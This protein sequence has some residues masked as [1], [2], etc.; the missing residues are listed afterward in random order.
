[1][2]VTK[3]ALDMDVVIHR[4]MGRE[5]APRSGIPG[6]GSTKLALGGV[7]FL[8]LTLGVLWWQVSQ[9]PPGGA[10]LT[11]VELRWGYL[12]LILLCLPV[13]TTASALRTWALC[14]VLPPRVTLWT[15]IKAEWA[16]V[17]ISLLTPSQSGGGPGQIYMLSRAGVS[18]PTALTISLI[19]FLGTMV[20]LFAM[21]LYSL[22][23]SGLAAT[24]P[25]L[26]G[27]I[28]ALTGISAAMLVAAL[29]PGLFRVALG[30]LSRAACRLA[31]AGEHLRDWWPPRAART[32]PPVDRMDPLTARL[33]DMIHTYR[34]DVRRFLRVGKASFA[35]VCLLSLVFLFSR[36]L[37]PYLCVRFL[38]IQASTLGGIVEAQMA[39]IFLVF[40][41]PTP[42]GA[43]LAEGASLSIMTAI[44]PMGFAPYYN[45]LWRFSTAYLAAIAGLVCLARAL[46]ADAR[47]TISTRRRDG[48]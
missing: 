23:V 26:A 9:I 16:N 36:C 2:V 4:E 43:G 7:T 34:D 29:A 8:G 17:A 35:W 24:G 31:G 39:L 15:A 3:E 44:V 48:S 18:V 12:A 33:A 14:R 41:A 27:A 47:A 6:L 25:L 1:M 37:L 21:G 13:E 32:G 45:L 38:G 5:E 11:W 19:S 22:F 10:A 40:F 30:T 42:G 46:G 20:G 28:W